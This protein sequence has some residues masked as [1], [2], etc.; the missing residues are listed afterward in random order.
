MIIQL[1]TAASPKMSSG[2]QQLE[3]K[4]F[5]TIASCTMI[6]IFLLLTN[7]FLQKYPPNNYFTKGDNN[8]APTPNLTGILTSWTS[9][10]LL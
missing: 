8:V 9:S 4:I 6:C 3:T 2:I 1:L 7:L 10:L 5:I